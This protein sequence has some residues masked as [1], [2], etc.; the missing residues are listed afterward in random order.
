MHWRKVLVYITGT[1]DND[2]L[3]GNEYLAA[4]YLILMDQLKGRLFLNDPDASIECH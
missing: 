4:E 3:L 1:V 2:L